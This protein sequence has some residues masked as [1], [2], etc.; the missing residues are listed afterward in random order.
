MKRTLIQLASCLIFPLFIFAQDDISSVNLREVEIRVFIEEISRITGNTYIV[1]DNVSGEVTVVSTSELQEDDV[2]R[3]FLSTLRS[4][5]YVAIPITDNTF[6]IAQI[7]QGIQNAMPVN[8]QETDLDTL[9]SRIFELNYLDAAILGDLLRPMISSQGQVIFQRGLNRVIVID[10]G[11]NIERIS[12]IITEVDQDPTYTERVNLENSSATEIAN[13]LERL[14]TNSSASDLSTVQLIPLESSN[15]LIVRGL[16]GQVE[17]IVDLAT[18][19]DIANEVRNSVKVVYLN[20]ANAEDLLP[21]LLQVSQSIT[22]SNPEMSGEGTVITAHSQTNSII[23]NASPDVQRSIESIIFQLDIRRAQV[24]VE[25]II[26]EVSDVAARDIGLQM[27]IWDE[28]SDNT[29]FVATNF[30]SSSPSLLSLAAAGATSNASTQAA[31]QLNSSA[32]NSLLGV[33]GAIAGAAGM[34]GGNLFA[35]ILTAVEQDQ[36]SNVLSTPSVMTLDNEPARIIVGQEIPITT[37]E[38]LLDQS[39]FRTVERQNVG[40]QLEVEPQITESGTIELQ[41][42]QE[43]SAV[44]GPA[45]EGINEL[46]TNKRELETRVLVDSG[47]VLVLGGLIE[48]NDQYLD[49][50]IPVLSNIPVLGRL[51][52]SRARSAQRTNLMVFIRPTIIF[53]ENASRVLTNQKYNW[54][55]NASGNYSLNTELLDQLILGQEQGTDE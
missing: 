49:D 36:A 43:V 46:I 51:F 18:D 52:G 4:S 16:R 35:T 53:D 22:D 38:A 7:T 25:A 34:V 3:V 2:Y 33:N 9:V 15:L 1:D 40:I 39:T 31:A 12:R 27:A 37:G 6:R 30:S 5:G 32:L 14:I 47:E 17:E 24:L 23:I 8:D 13:I 10:F 29:P 50:G 42:R 45:S 54:I 11:I 48:Q 19:L 28:Q 20:Y 26:V 41:I 44:A 55:R 21:L